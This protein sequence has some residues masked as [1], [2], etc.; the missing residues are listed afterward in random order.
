MDFAVVHAVLLLFL[1]PPVG[2][3]ISPFAVDIFPDVSYVCSASTQPMVL[4]IEKDTLGNRAIL[5]W[6]TWTKRYHECGSHFP[7]PDVCMPYEWCHIGSINKNQ[8]VLW[9]HQSTIPFIHHGDGFQQFQP[10]FVGDLHPQYGIG[11]I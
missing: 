2:W 1:L 7:D 8:P 10:S 11:N 5:R 6:S 9:S 4:A 3:S